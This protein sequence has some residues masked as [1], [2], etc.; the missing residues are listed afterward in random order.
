[1]TELEKNLID[2]GANYSERAENEVRY[3]VNPEYLKQL[4]AKRE[5][6]DI[7]AFKKL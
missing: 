1:M 3:A 4:E 6:D 5:Q 2:Y 7:E